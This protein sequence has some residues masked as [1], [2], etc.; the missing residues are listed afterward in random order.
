MG[1]LDG[2]MNPAAVGQGLVQAFEAGAQ[3]RADVETRNAL[4]AFAV[5]P[6]DEGAFQTLA[7]YR[8]EMAMQV[9]QQ[10]DAA[11]VQAEKKDAYR[12]YGLGD[13]SALVD[14]WGFD[15]DVAM[16]LTDQQLGKAKEGVDF[17]ANAAFNIVKLPEEQRAAAWDAYI[18][19]G[20]GMGFDGLAE[21]RGGYTPDALNS[22]V[23][24]AG[25]TQKFETYQQ[26]RYVAVGETGLQ[27]TQFGRP[28]G[29]I[30]G[31]APVPAT[32]SLPPLPP[33]SRL[34]PEGGGGGAPASGG[35]PD[36]MKV[37]FANTTSGRRTPE[38]NRAV[39]GKPGSHHL[40]GDAADYTPA[41]GQ[42]M[43]Q[44]ERQLRQHFGSGARYLNE[45][46]HVHVTL[47]GYGRVPYYGRNGTRGRR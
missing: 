35:F 40:S 34:L 42:S 3:K 6:N 14:V 45:G 41:Q 37:P 44:L 7:K 24:Q 29:D 32:T 20:V 13:R 47:P 5:N 4:S 31:A 36:P 27:P 23:A 1:A 39:G 18:E 9:R 38:G 30:V 8:P 26:P 19:R 25:Q 21:Y 28:T 46:D 43:G 22:L 15:P 2:L 33:G 12:R 17:I 16:K 10:R 11:K